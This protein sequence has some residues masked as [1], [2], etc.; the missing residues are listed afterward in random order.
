MVKN[1]SDS[2]EESLRQA[3]LDATSGDTITFDPLL[4]GDTIKLTGDEITLD[5]N[6][7]IM[8]NDSTNT[9]IDGM[10]NSRIFHI[11]PLDT[12]LLEGLKVQNG[13]GNGLQYS[14]DG[15]AIL[16]QGNL[17][18]SQISIEYNEAEDGGGI[19]NLGSLFLNN[20]SIL[21]N[22]AYFQGGGFFNTKGNVTAFNSIISSNKANNG[23]GFSNH[24]NSSVIILT[25]TNIH[26]NIAD[27]QG[28]GIY[29][30]RGTIILNHSVISS[31]SS[32]RFWGGG[33]LN[34]LGKVSFNSSVISE[35]KSYSCGGGMFNLSGAAIFNNSYLI[36]NISN[37]RGG[38]LFNLNGD[39]IA[40][41]TN[42]II[43]GNSASK[44]GGGILDLGRASFYNCTISGNSS[45]SGA[46]GLVS[47]RY[48]TFFS[49]SIL[50]K[51]NSNT[52][53]PLDISKG[54][55]TIIDG[56][57]NHVMEESGGHNISNG[58]GI[59]P[60]F[61]VN[62]PTAPSTGG[63][64]RLQ[65]GSPAIDA[66]SSDTSGLNLGLIDLLGLPRIA[67]ERIDIG[68]FEKEVSCIELDLFDLSGESIT[69]TTEIDFGDTDE[70]STR[71]FFIRNT[72]QQQLVIDS[73]RIETVN[74]STTSF[75]HNE[76]DITEPEIIE[77][78]DSIIL[79]ITFKPKDS[80][81]NEAVLHIYNNDLDEAIFTLS[82]IA[83]KDNPIEEALIIPT[84]GEW[85]ILKL[86]V[87][88]MILCVV[89]IRQSINFTSA[90][91]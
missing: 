33:V 66:G 27:N 91:S 73:I 39:G 4:N 71:T 18:C 81:R 61:I 32:E 76:F 70:I 59:D 72:G 52:L 8:G 69:N 78:G 20:S 35:N 36:G 46:G 5:K 79:T 7:V 13:N 11:T 58:N 16:N 84:L 2:G 6:L 65:C 56:G 64:L 85:A 28:G 53:G 90:G 77:S 80:F 34:N 24:K 47:F 86:M 67:G 19:L 55:G 15:G 48:S 22:I 88:M 25:N 40:I 87:I 60:L 51:N 9:I 31:N 38:G 68:A 62:V 75:S 89:S 50:A 57:N 42:S 54:T 29:N 10:G 43:S 41:F 83:N 21:N 82:L 44:G 49:N 14:L 45:I 26:N 17:L 3:V 12:I 1:T 74:G 30:S 63:D 37:D 23:G